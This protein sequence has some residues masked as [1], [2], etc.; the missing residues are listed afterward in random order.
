MN[1]NQELTYGETWISTRKNN[2]EQ[3][4]PVAEAEDESYPVVQKSAAAEKNISI[5]VLGR[6]IVQ[7]YSQLFQ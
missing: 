1:R 7:Y 2:I 5:G 6:I 4:D 3:D